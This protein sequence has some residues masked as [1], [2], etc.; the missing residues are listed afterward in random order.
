MN[1]RTLSLGLA[2]AVFAAGLLVASAPVSAQSRVGDPYCGF[3]QNGSWVANGN[4]AGYM[5]SM[6]RGMVSGTITSV[7]GH[8]VTIQQTNG[9][10]VINDTPALRRRT[11]GRVAVGRQITATGY[12]RAGTFYATNIA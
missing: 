9:S 11:S 12:W 6:R 8:L 7:S 1:A 10:I 5:P 4:C 2:G 3:W